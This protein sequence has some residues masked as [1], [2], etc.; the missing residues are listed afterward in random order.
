MTQRSRYVAYIP[1][2]KMEKARQ[3]GLKNF[4]QLCNESVE[5]FIRRTD[6]EK[7]TKGWL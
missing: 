7:T 3:C 6:A 5:Q 1:P 2:E 4:S